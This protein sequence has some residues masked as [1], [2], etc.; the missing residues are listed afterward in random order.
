M[1]G[2]ALLF[3]IFLRNKVCLFVLKKSFLKINKPSEKGALDAN[4][5]NTKSNMTYI[6]NEYILFLANSSK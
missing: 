3:L 1:G 6:N 4:I 5:L 2:V